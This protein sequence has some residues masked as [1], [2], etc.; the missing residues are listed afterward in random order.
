MKY[1]K[2]RKRIYELAKIKGLGLSWKQ[3]K[4]HAKVAVGSKQV[5]VPRHV[6]V[7]EMTARS[8]LE[9]LFGGCEDE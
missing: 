3:G 9:T 8:I 1:R 2:L 5:T 7:N 4:V 6:E